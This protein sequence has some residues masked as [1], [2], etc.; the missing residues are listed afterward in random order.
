MTVFDRRNLQDSDFFLTPLVNIRPLGYLK[1]DS[2]ALSGGFDSTF[3]VSEVATVGNMSQIAD[4]DIM[5]AAGGFAGGSELHAHGKGFLSYA[6]GYLSSKENEATTF[7]RTM[8]SHLTALPSLTQGSVAAE[9][10]KTL[11]IWRFGQWWS[12]TVR[13][14]CNISYVSDELV[15][16]NSSIA[17]GPLWTWNDAMNAQLNN[18]E[19]W[20]LMQ[21]EGNSSVKYEVTLQVNQINTVPMCG[22][23][24]GTYGNCNLDN[25]WKR[26]PTLLSVVPQQAI[27]GAP[28]VSILAGNLILNY[29]SDNSNT[30]SYFYN[31]GLGS[32]ANRAGSVSG[33]TFSGLN[34]QLFLGSHSNSDCGDSL[35]PLNG[36]MTTLYS[37]A[38][39]GMLRPLPNNVDNFFTNRTI[40]YSDERCGSRLSGCRAF[41]DSHHNMFFNKGQFILSNSLVD[42]FKNKVFSAYSTQGQLTL[43]HAGGSCRRKDELD[44]NYRYPTSTA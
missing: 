31:N 17:S 11:T 9:A 18:L 40:R 26:T 4:G 38:Q 8:P 23:G 1:I 5:K 43:H 20:R 27:S 25:E 19:Y 30:G 14:P 37:A 6:P 16:C 12:H 13:A 10:S 44:R 42:A 29:N 32:A 22:G 3:S 34:S 2:P 28:L 36:N 21:Y 15:R 24:Q 7:Q 35:A 39:Q 41:Y 33:S